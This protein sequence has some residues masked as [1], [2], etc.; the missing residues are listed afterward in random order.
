MSSTVQ[1][2]NHSE[3]IRQLHDKYGQSHPDDSLE[4]VLVLN[5]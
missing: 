1:G 5:P 2:R 4:Y 3:V